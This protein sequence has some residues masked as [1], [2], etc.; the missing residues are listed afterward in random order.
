[1]VTALLPQW[2][3]TPGGSKSI[4]VDNGQIA[5]DLLGQK[6]YGKSNNGITKLYAQLLA[7]KLNFANGASSA[8][9]DGVVAEADAFLA[10]HDYMDWKDLDD[11]TQ[12]IIL[13]WHGTIDDYNNG[14]LG[15]PH[16]DDDDDGG[17]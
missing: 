17:H 16:C 13:D 7:A 11:D 14:E 6:V 4:L 1:M 10:D 2:L 5:H 15:V 9:V 8:P 3:G 12:Q